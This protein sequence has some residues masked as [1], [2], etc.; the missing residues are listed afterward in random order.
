M[1]ST[2]LVVSNTASALELFDDERIN[3]TASRPFSKNKNVK[4]SSELTTMSLSIGRLYERICT[5]G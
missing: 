1:K 3:R 5:A 4:H 2:A